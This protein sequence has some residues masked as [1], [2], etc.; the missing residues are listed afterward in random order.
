MVCTITN[1]NKL[2][3]HKNNELTIYHSVRVANHEE[4][5]MQ[6]IRRFCNTFDLSELPSWPASGE[7]P[8]LNAMAT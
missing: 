5:P 4:C 2:K 1:K 8:S 3:G 7:L 6:L